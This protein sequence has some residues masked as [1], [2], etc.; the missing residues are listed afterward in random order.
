M[1]YRHLSALMVLL[2][3]VSPSLSGGEWSAIEQWLEQDQ[4]RGRF[5]A[6]T[7]QELQQLQTITLRLL[8]DEGL[9]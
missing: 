3:V 6:P 5:V 4:G 7:P 1:N 8:Q 9:E 2:W